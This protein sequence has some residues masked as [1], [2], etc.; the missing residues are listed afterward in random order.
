MPA[1]SKIL[2]TLC[3]VV[4]GMAIAEPRPEHMVYLRT[5][6]PSIE[7]DIRYATAHNFTGHPLDG[8]EAPECLLSVDAA[9]ALAGFKPHCV[10]KAT[11]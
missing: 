5:I 10:P 1:L 2:A 6:A 9:K 7:Q 11:G 8:Y 4:P 3:L